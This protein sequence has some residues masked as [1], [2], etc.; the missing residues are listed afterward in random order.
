MVTGRNSISSQIFMNGKTAQRTTQLNNGTIF[1]RYRRPTACSTI[2]YW[3]NNV[4]CLSVTLCTD[5]VSTIGLYIRQ[6]VTASVWTS[7]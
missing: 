2:G 3:C 1:S 7:K 4:V 5:C 6:Q